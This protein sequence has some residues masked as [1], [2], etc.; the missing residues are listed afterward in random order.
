MPEIKDNMT[1]K[2]NFVVRKAEKLSRAVYVVSDFM[3]DREP[4]KWRLRELAVEITESLGKDIAF[5]MEI[6]AGKIPQMISVIDLALG[7]GSVSQ[8]NFTLLRK[9]YSDLYATI[10]SEN[11]SFFS[12][13]MEVARVLPAGVGNE[14]PVRP[15]TNIGEESKNPDKRQNT[16][17]RQIKDTSTLRT[18]TPS[19]S[20]GHRQ[21]EIIGF[22]KGKDWV[23]I[24]DIVQIIPSVSAKTIQ[25]ELTDLV[26]KGTL[27]KKGERRWSR[28]ALA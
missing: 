16:P 23:S 24:K 15:S 27:R 19:V 2:L 22:L 14:T 20:K 8:M 5:T 9:E 7:T 18:E 17:I 26:A 25:R 12:N 11:R 10:R 13:Q 21:E 4:I 1:D 3:S 6:L 28:Y